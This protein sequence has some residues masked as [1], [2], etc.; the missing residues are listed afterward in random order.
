MCVAGRTGRWAHSEAFEEK[1]R[2]AGS[3]AST[4]SE[5]NL[6]SD[7]N[8]AKLRFFPGYC[9]ELWRIGGSWPLIVGEVVAIRQFCSVRCGG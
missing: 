2:S 8:K 1:L 5:E 4:R 3:F 9:Y 6:Q 7:F